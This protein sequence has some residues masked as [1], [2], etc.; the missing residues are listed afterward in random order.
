MIQWKNEILQENKN[1][2]FNVNALRAYAIILIVLLHLFVHTGSHP[3]ARKIGTHFD[4]AF[5]VE[6]FFV[7]AGYFLSLHLLRKKAAEK[8]REKSGGKG[9]AYDVVIFIKKRLNRLL[10]V[11]L[12][13]CLIPL[14]LSCLHAHPAWLAPGEMWRKF[15]SGITML[16]NFEEM[17]HQTA[18][19]YFWAVS[20]EF[21]FFLVFTLLF[22]YLDSKILLSVSFIL[23]CIFALYRTEIFF[24]GHSWMFRIDGFLWGYILAYIQVKVPD[25]FQAVSD[26]LN[27]MGRGKAILWFFFILLASLSMTQNF[28]SNI[29]ILYSIKAMMAFFLVLWCVA[30]PHSLE[31]PLRP[32][33][34]T[35][36]YLGIYSYS[37]YAVHIPAYF[38]TRTIFESD[39]VKS[40]ISLSPMSRFSI[41]IFLTLVLATLTYKFV[42]KRKWF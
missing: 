35:I 40:H 41:A 31:L 28:I 18:F 37:I 27:N 16:R 4:L 14:I 3:I 21:Q 23:L 9:T 38:I 19:G 30:S 5:G 33:E 24:G 6:I 22:Y 20:L 39:L 25:S 1:F 10:P 8:D 7:M 13:W 29:S 42:E 32:L 12:V 15:I 26:S 11:V 36:L 17:S 2:N 34:Y